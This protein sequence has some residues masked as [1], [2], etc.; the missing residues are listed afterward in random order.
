V[1]LEKAN[2]WIMQNLGK[3]LFKENSGNVLKNLLDMLGEDGP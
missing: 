2:C 3:E 1:A